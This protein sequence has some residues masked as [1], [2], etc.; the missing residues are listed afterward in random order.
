MENNQLNELEGKVLPI[1]LPPPIY[2]SLFAADKLSMIMLNENAKNWLYNNFIQLVFYAQNLE[3]MR[4]DSHYV[5]IWPVDTMKM[6]YSGANKFL[7]EYHIN[8]KMYNLT[9]E[10]LI[11]N[12]KNWIDCGFYIIGYVDVTKLHGTRYYGFPAYSHSAMLI[13]Y[14]DKELYQVDFSPRGNI[15][16]L[17][18]TYEDYI[19]AVF[20]EE[21]QVIFKEKKHMDFKFSF[22]LFELKDAFRS[23]CK[24]DLN[25]MKFWTKSFVDGDDCGIT[26]DFFMR[27]D[28]LITGINVYD[29]MLKLVDIMVD[30]NNDIDYKMFHAVYEHKL[31]MKDRVSYLLAQDY[32]NHNQEL[33]NIAQKNLEITQILRNYVLKYNFTHNK[34]IIDKISQNMQLL[35]LQEYDFMNAFY[36]EL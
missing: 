20:S 19:E 11:D 22:S 1:V 26:T 12:I 28:E 34:K 31:I 13:G 15:D 3:K 21:L 27:R 17:R 30:N 33:L 23:E 4:Y 29:N 10:N 8:D 32:L 35:K 18:I 25:V 6:D 24:L 9:R 16:I 5:S 2:Y 36:N 14:N 7:R